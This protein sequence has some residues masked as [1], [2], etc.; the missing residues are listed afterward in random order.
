MKYLIVFLFCA[1]F[2]FAQSPIQ[3]WVSNQKGNTLEMSPA[4]LPANRFFLYSLYPDEKPKGSVKSWLQTLAEQ[5][6][7]T[8]G[9]SV[10]PFQYSQNGFVHLWL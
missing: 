8:L 10:K 1:S 2:S 9:K 7:A 5:D 6:A 3:G 4:Q